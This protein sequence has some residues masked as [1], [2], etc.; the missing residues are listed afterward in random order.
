MFEEWSPPLA[1]LDPHRR[2][3]LLGLLSSDWYRSSSSKSEDVSPSVD[4]DISNWSGLSDDSESDD[5]P[6]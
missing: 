6:L 5:E 3:F 1:L 2:R 4:L